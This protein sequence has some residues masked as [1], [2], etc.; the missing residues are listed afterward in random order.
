M[1]I[2]FYAILLLKVLKNLWIFCKACLYLHFY[3]SCPQK[4]YIIFLKLPYQTHSTF[5]GPDFLLEI[6][7]DIPSPQKSSLC[8]FFL[9]CLFSCHPHSSGEEPIMLLA[10]HTEKDYALDSLIPKV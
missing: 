1:V 10:G 2:I 5:Q 6:N 7:S 3:L 9:L 4:L 8:F